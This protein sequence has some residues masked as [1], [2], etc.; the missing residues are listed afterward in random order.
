MEIV[1]LLRGVTP[2]GKNRIPKMAYVVEILEKVGLKNVRTYIQ[3]GNIILE[4]ELS[5]EETAKLIHDTIA[6]EVGADLSVI[7]KEK[8]QL[9]IAVE[10]NPFNENYDFSRIHL[11]FTNDSIGKDELKKLENK[12]FGDE[13]FIIGSECLY[14]YLP[15]N[16]SVKRLT[17]NYLEK[18]L[19]ITMTMRKLNVIEHLVGLCK[20]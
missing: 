12:D 14:M 5:K 4:T 20:K 8:I 18:Q 7:I 1:A 2:T 6:K 10:E 3:S 9:Q 16:A 19:S 17:T 11:V 13:K 15:R